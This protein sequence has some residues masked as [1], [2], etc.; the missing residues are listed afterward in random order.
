MEVSIEELVHDPARDERST[1][2]R[3]LLGPLGAGILVDD[4]LQPGRDDLPILANV[5]GEVADGTVQSAEPG[6]VLVIIQRRSRTRQTLIGNGVLQLLHLSHLLEVELLD[7]GIF[8]F[9]R[10][11]PPRGQHRD[12]GG[13]IIMPG[14]T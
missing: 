4:G 12:G 9:Y 14:R 2:H 3:H 8:L 7:L 6:G 5:E 13:G 1:D 10:I 11:S